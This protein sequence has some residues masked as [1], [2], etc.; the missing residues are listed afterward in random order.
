MG[1]DGVG[2]WGVG[3]IVWY[4]QRDLFSFWS[5]YLS[6]ST[7]VNCW[8]ISLGCDNSLTSH[9]RFV[10]CHQEEAYSSGLVIFRSMLTFLDLLELRVT[11][12]HHEKW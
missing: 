8:L 1:K 11:E 4:P 2:E 12:V 7:L 6:P 9:G 5:S 10:G 3:G